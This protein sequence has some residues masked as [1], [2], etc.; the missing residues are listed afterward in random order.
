MEVKLHH[1]DKPCG[2]CREFASCHREDMKEWG[3]MDGRFYLGV[4]SHA[5]SDGCACIRYTMPSDRH[6]V[7]WCHV[8][9][10]SP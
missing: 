1:P 10:T 2:A 7:T 4:F 5:R 6:A 8:P 9:V 3:E